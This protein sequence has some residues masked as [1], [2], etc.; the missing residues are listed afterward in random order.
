[1]KRWNIEALRWAG[2]RVGRADRCGGLPG[3]KRLHLA[4]TAAAGGEGARSP[5]IGGC[6]GPDL[7]QAGGRAGGGHVA[8]GAGSGLGGVCRARIV[9]KELPEVDP[10]FLRLLPMNGRM[11]PEPALISIYADEERQIHRNLT[12]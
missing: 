12:S 2:A 8:S 3:G 1:M 5:P 11:N 10:G 6:C 7:G 4:G 9:S